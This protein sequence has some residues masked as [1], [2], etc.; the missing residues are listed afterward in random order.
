MSDRLIERG[1]AQVLG[2]AGERI[3]LGDE[4]R[5]VTVLGREK[6][7]VAVDGEDPLHVVAEVAREV[8]ELGE[9][10]AALLSPAGSP[11]GLES[12][13]ERVEERLAV[14]ARPRREDDVGRDLL[15]AVGTPSLYGNGR[16]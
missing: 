6:E 8:S 12:R 14:P 5:H 1:T 10:G 15:A 13:V 9:Q 2:E 11:D 3:E 16:R 7:R 4:R